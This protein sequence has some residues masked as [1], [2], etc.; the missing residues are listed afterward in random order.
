M[1]V[2]VCVCVCVGVRVRVSAQSCTRVRKLAAHLSPQVDLSR[3]SPNCVGKVSNSP[4]TPTF[5]T[6]F[7]SYTWFQV[8]ANMLGTAFSIYDGGLNPAKAAEG[9]VRQELAAVEYAPDA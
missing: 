8:R 9:G 4:Q 1:R 6:K 2:C 5:T 3:K 7:Q